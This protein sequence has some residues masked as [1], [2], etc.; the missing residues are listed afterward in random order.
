MS[1]VMVLSRGIFNGKISY[2][3]L[4]Y[5][6]RRNSLVQVMKI[7]CQKKKSLLLKIFSVLQEVMC[8][9]HAFTKW[10]EGSK[11][12]PKRYITLIELI[13]NLV[14]KMRANY[15]F[16]LFS[17]HQFIYRT[18]SPTCLKYHLCFHFSFFSLLI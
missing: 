16:P 6:T 17:I 13:I 10:K 15:K 7:H 8:N 9:L 4:T 3:S 11:H 1:M 14:G 18:L 5:F 2:I 12:F